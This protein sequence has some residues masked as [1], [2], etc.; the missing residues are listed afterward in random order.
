MRRL[1]SHSMGEV[2]YA[3]LG[4]GRCEISWEEVA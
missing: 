1:P 4:V 2:V 3:L